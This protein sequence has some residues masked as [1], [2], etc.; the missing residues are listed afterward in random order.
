MRLPGASHR[1]EADVRGRVGMSMARRVMRHH[2]R[3][4]HRS[5]ITSPQ[6]PRRGR[7]ETSCDRRTRCSVR[8]R[9]GHARARLLGARGMEEFARGCSRDSCAPQQ[10]EV[11][12]R[13]YG[14]WAPDACRFPRCLE[15]YFPPR[16]EAAVSA[17]PTGLPESNDD[18]DSSAAARHMRARAGGV[19]WS[20]RSV[21]NHHDARRA[22][23]SRRFAVLPGGWD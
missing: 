13:G 4:R 16:N 21:H 18:A 3:A 5:I 15:F 8:P 12:G 6:P 1:R 22:G 23:V 10:E 2:N 11:A 19:F 9:S 20:L 17:A 14:T 7:D